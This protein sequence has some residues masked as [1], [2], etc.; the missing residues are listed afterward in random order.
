M[1]HRKKL[2]KVKVLGIKYDIVSG[3]MVL[4]A[5]NFQNYNANG[6]Q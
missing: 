4:V 1:K 3:R 5:D 6:L 2:V